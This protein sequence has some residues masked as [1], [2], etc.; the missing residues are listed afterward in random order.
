[1]SEKQLNMF[2][3]S[4]LNSAL[5][6]KDLRFKVEGQYLERKGRDAKRSK[7]ANELVGMLNARGGTLVYGI[8]KDGTVE[9]LRTL[10]A[11]TL[12]LYRRL[13]HDLIEPSASV[14]LEELFLES[15]ELIFLFHVDLDF[16]RLFQ[17]QDSEEV[18]LRV[19]DTNR[20]PLGRTEVNLLEHNKSLRSFEEEKRL[21]CSLSDLNPELCRLYVELT[22]FS[23]EFEDLAVSRHLAIR[24]NNQ[25]IYKNAAILLFAKDPEAFIPNATARYVRYEGTERRSGR[26]FNVVKDQRFEGSIPGLIQKLEA[27][28][29]AS[30]RDY[31]FLDIHEGKFKKVPEF[32]K[33]AWFEGIV[34]ALCHRSYNIQGNPVMIRHFDDRLEIANSGPLPAQVTVENIER[35]RFSRNPRI[36]RALVDLGFVRELNEG[37]PRIISVMEQSLLARPEYRDEE[38]T[39]TL[40]LRNKVSD[41]KE[42][43]LAEVFE[44]I[45]TTW[46][47]MNDNQ[48]QILLLL[49]DVAEVTIAD[50]KTCLE[51]SERTI[52]YNLKKLEEAGIVEKVSKKQRDRDAL[53][54]FPSD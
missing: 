28:L 38:N 42:T 7:I 8:A 53:Y 20:G 41:H 26:D 47:G 25:V 52:R 30:M 37:V 12:N 15:G 23:G 5:T 6:L 14:Q 2:S 24:E 43:I 27:F 17:R 16:E 13:V 49:M 4:Q 22:R 10:D 29:E 18:Y 39:V 32:P 50:V 34:N 31:Y 40:T 44:R 9:D 51:K 45:E 11:D 33:E 3:L 35:E 54:R 48:K 46:E 1:M 19:A 36:A 21:D